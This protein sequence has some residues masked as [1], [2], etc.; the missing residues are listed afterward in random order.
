MFRCPNCDH[1]LNQTPE[2]GAPC[3]ICGTE[4]NV[5]KPPELDP[6]WVA[7]KA[8]K[9]AA[10]TAPPN[11]PSRAVAMVI[12]SVVMAAAVIVIVVMVLQRQPTAKGADVSGGA[13][14]TVHSPRPTPFTIDGV[15]GGTTP[16]SFKLKGRGRPITITGNG[17]SKTITPDRDQVVDLVP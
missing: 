17:V 11:K 9:Q 3:P 13:E 6:E 4:M 2:P 1:E 10:G 7:E 14:I 5:A 16:Q 15:K 12:L 8:A